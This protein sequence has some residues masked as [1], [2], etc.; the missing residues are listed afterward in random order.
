MTPIQTRVI[1]SA[2]LAFLLL[3]NCGG[4]SDNNT[5]AGAGGTVNVGGIS[6]PSGSGGAGA[7]VTGGL[8]GTGGYF[9]P[10][11]GGAP[12]F[13][14][15]TGGA[16]PNSTGTGGKAP[17][18]G[19]VP[20]TGGTLG[21]GGYDNYST[22]G[23]VTTGGAVQNTGGA[24][25]GGAPPNGHTCLCAL[26]DSL[27]PSWSVTGCTSASPNDCTLQKAYCGQTCAGQVL[28]CGTYCMETFTGQG[29][30]DAS[31]YTSGSCT[32]TVHCP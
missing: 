32:V 4:N 22:G 11:T 2:L 26:A 21:T 3:P 20:S 27:E 28:D 6:S 16:P 5:N 13:D 10:K 30:L 29:F 15:G 31:T 1:G 23:T 8:P 19:G 7:W 9:G 24:G 18:T 12:P 25:T 14:T 17:G